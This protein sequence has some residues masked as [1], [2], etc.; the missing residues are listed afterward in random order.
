MSAGY[1]GKA[2]VDWL[3]LAAFSRKP[4]GADMA[5]CQAAMSQRGP[6]EAY[7]DIWWALI[8]SNEFILNH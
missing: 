6:V 8:N 2:L 5:M 3:Y 4:S 7:Q 1:E